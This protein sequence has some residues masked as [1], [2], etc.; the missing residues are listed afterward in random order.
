MMTHDR[1]R[2]MA[3]LDREIAAFDAM[4]GELESHSLGKWVVFYDQKL[5]GLFESF[6]AA[7]EEAVKNFGSGPYLIRQVGEPPV[8]LPASVMYHPVHA[9]DDTLRLQ[10]HRDR[11]WQG[12]SG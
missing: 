11:A 5:I 7:A 10:Q 8:T 3:D 4:R 2:E 9:E 12:S 1:K 6:E